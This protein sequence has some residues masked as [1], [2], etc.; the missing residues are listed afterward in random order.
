MVLHCVTPWPWSRVR[1][2]PGRP[3][4]YLAPFA[5]P[6][7]VSRHFPCEALL[8]ALI[9][10]GL[11]PALD[12]TPSPAC[13]LQCQPS[14]G[15]DPTTRCPS[16]IHPRSPSGLEGGQR[17]EVMRIMRRTLARAYGHARTRVPHVWT[18]IVRHR[19][20]HRYRHAARAPERVRPPT[21][22]PSVLCPCSYARHRSLPASQRYE[23]SVKVSP[24]VRT[25]VP[26]RL[27]LS[28]IEIACGVSS[29]RRRVQIES[30][31]GQ[32][33]DADAGRLQ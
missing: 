1:V 30:R 24:C 6:G 10:A 8:I 27:G 9:K 7:R 3:W 5:H 26:K 18:R 28:R 14:P 2:M 25:R 31:R 19:H 16:T 15:S 29:R 21:W 20:C 23:S 12:H 17:S 32:H 4:L 13:Q 22:Q 33:V 11:D